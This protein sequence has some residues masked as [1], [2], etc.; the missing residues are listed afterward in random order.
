MKN[1]YLLNTEMPIDGIV[2]GRNA[3]ESLTEYREELIKALINEK[4]I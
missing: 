2:I 4:N 1:I 3:G